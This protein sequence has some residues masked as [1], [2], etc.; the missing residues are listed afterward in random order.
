VP[1]GTKVSRSRIYQTVRDNQYN[2]TE[3][4]TG[5]AHIQARELYA[6]LQECI[7]ILQDPEILAYF[8]G[9]RRKTLWTVIELLSKQEFG[10]SPNIAAIRSLAVDGNTIFKFIADFSSGG[11]VREE[12]FD[13]YLRACEAY[14]LNYS[15]ISDDLSGID[16]NDEEEEVDSEEEEFAEDDF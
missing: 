1:P 16:A 10:A 2:L 4:C 15:T 9:N 12:D 8:G 13:T 6:Q 3:F 14:I 5:M 11:A 7:A